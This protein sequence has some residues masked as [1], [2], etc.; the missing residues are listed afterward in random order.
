MPDIG[1]LAPRLRARGIVSR[2]ISNPLARLLIALRV[3]PNAIT[4]AGFCVA[5]YSAY[6]IADGRLFIGGV[7]MLAGAAMD[8]LDGAVARLS[9][10]ASTF[11]AFFDSVMD[12]LGE[13]VVLFGLAVYY[14]RGDDALGVYL[15]FAAL[16][17]SMMVSYLRARAEGLAI[18]G[19]VGLMGR[20]E[21]VVVLGVALLAGYPSYGLGLIAAFASLTVLQRGWGVWRATR[22]GA[23]DG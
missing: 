10:K 16:T 3:S 9:G 1:S 12:R 6:L 19:D 17:S 8:M 21:R 15:A 5:A 23:S 22:S 20:P 14:T 18:P 2:F 4:L 7:V 13:A 11:G